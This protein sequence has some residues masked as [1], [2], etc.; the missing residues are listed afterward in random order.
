MRYYG[1]VYR[2]P[3]EANSFILQV[4]LGCSHNAC[5]FCSMYKK[6]RFI[7]RPLEDVLADLME[8]SREYPS[9]RRV[10]LADGDALAADTADLLKILDTIWRVFPRCE[11]VTA[12]AS[13]GS[14]LRKTE[15]ERKTI[16]EAGLKMLYMG[17]ESGN[18]EVLKRM[19]KGHTA[20]AIIQAGRKAKEEI[21]R[22]P[23]SM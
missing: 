9:V 3:S 14:I 6:K 21:S 11:R 4:T 20:E 19:R 2:P 22:R 16:R 5:A 10:F 17:L 23:R 1:D 18:D 7:V 13:P 8:V 12:Y 15:E